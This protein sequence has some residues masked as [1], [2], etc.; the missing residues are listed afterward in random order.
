MGAIDVFCILTLEILI[1]G[2][3]QVRVNNAQN[4]VNRSMHDFMIFN[5]DSIDGLVKQNKN[6]QEKVDLLEAAVYYNNEE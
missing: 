5:A 6:L 1:L 2:I 4:D 3:L